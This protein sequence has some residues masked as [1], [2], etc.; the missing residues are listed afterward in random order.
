V[1]R[2]CRP[3]VAGISGGCREIAS[4]CL[5]QAGLGP[6]GF[7]SLPGCLAGRPSEH[8]AHELDLVNEEADC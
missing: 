8:V 3:F 1:I 5:R 2:E 7:A 4:P 6:R